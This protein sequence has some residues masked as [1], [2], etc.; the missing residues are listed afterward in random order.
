MYFSSGGSVIHSEV[1]RE[2]HGTV[3]GVYKIQSKIKPERIYIGS[4]VNIPR[5]WTD[6]LYMLARGSHHSVKLQRHFNKYG[7]NDLV[8]SVLIGCDKED[9]IVTEQFYI[10]AYNPWFNILPKAGSMLGHKQTKESIQKSVENRRWYKHSEE[11]KQ[12]ISEAHKGKKASE[13][14]RAKLSVARQ[15][16]SEETKRKIAEA[17]RGTKISEE[18]RI[19]MSE[20]RKGR[21]AHNKGD[22]H[23]DETRKKISDKVRARYKDPEYIKKLSDSQ[24]KRWEGRARKPIKTPEEKH[25]NYSEAM[26][27]RWLTPE[28]R[29][30]MKIALNKTTLISQVFEN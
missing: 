9:L 2:N 14:T 12:K 24:K 4:A 28:Y 11:T 3:S 19:K 17:K 22:I 10:D 27:K 26:K 23:S 6:H 25:K 13:E 1:M 7:K 30:R 8:F 16:M 29:M 18:A 20:T 21:P 5:R 15:N